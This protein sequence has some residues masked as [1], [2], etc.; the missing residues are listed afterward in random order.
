MNLDNINDKFFDIIFEQ[1]KYILILKEQIEMVDN[2]YDSRYGHCGW[3]GKLK[4]EKCLK[5]INI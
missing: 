5:W 2:N 4:C 3:C 1:G